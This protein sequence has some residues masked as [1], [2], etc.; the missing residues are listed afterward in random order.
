VI[1]SRRDSQ[2]NNQFNVIGYRITVTLMSEYCDNTIRTIPL[3]LNNLKL[4]EFTIQPHDERSR[5][6]LAGRGGGGKK[7]EKAESPEGTG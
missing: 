2:E 1:S 6:R 4:N 3:G 7:N 5:R